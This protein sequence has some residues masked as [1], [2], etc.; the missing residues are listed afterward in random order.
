MQIYSR[1]L[2]LDRMNWNIYDL[3]IIFIDQQEKESRTKLNAR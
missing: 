2:N 1:I 3:T